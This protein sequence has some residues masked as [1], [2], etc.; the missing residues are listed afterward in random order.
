VNVQPLGKVQS[1]YGNNGEDGYEGAFYRHAIA[2][3]SHGPFLPKNP[4]VADW[5]IKTALQEKYQTEI[6]FNFP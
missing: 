6:D 3:Y 2:T 4:F 5:L 1:G